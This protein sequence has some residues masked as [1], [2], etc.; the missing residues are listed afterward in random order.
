[1]PS[2][3]GSNEYY[4]TDGCSGMLSRSWRAVFRKPPPWEGCCEGHD[5]AYRTGGTTGVSRF[6]ADI[7]LMRCLIDK[8][9]PHPHWAYFIY[10]VLRLF[11]GW[12]WPKPWGYGVRKP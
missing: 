10:V 1:M 7:N 8:S 11:G 4:T 6:D 3:G 5:H 12:C 9:E 2:T